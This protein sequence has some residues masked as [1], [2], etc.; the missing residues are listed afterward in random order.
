MPTVPVG[1]RCEPS[2]PCTAGRGKRGSA[3]SMTRSNAPRN[4]RVQQSPASFGVLE[5][6]LEVTSST[7]T[8]AC[9]PAPAPS[10]AEREAAAAGWHA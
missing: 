1:A 2:I 7:R 8:T 10:P 5:A 4:R 6:S 9:I 3:P